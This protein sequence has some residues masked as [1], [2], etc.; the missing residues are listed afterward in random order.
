MT[1]SNMNDAERQLDGLLDAIGKR[2]EEEDRQTQVI[3]LP[4][5]KQLEF[6]FEALKILL[7]DQDVQIT[8]K[9]NEPFK[10][11]GSV[12]VEGKS[13]V[14]S[15]TEWFTR[16]AKAASNVEVYPLANGKLRMTFTFHG[17]T[18]PM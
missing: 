3:N 17:L 15:R 6:A 9:L 10:S 7:K 2:I 11:M 12:S 4:R 8:T 1:G 16:V 13:I 5:V 18:T 14:F